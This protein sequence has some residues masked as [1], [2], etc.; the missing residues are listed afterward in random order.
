MKAPER[1]YSKLDEAA[2]SRPTRWCTLSLRSSG[3]SRPGDYIEEEVT[4]T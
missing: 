4:Y 3:R 1:S 2:I